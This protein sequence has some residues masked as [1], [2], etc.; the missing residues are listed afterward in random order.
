MV[1]AIVKVRKSV[2]RKAFIAAVVIFGLIGAVA[3]VPVLSTSLSPGNP[4]YLQSNTPPQFSS[5]D[6]TL[7]IEENTPWFSTI[8]SPITATDS[9]T[10]AYSLENS[11]KS[12]FTID[13]ATGQLKTGSPLNYESRSSY[14]VKVTASDPSGA[15]AS[16]DVTINVIN[17]DESG[18]VSLSWGQPQVGTELT[19]TLSDPDGTISGE[20][21]Q[22]SRSVNRDSGFSDINGAT[23]ASYTPGTGDKSNYL[24]ATVSY[25]DAQGQGKSAQGT[26][27]RRAR[28][29][30]SSNNAPAFPAADDIYGGYACSGSDPDRGVCLYVRRST[31]VGGEIYNPAR[32]EDPD[33]GR[34][35]LLAGGYRHCLFQN[36]LTDWPTLHKAA[37]QGL[38][39]HNLLGYDKGY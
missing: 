36:R 30:P 27:L 14:M 32:A 9:D 3:L 19:A 39:Q 15:S 38:R 6:I 13:R 1:G 10:L 8:G 31:P 18:K 33:G 23:A 28:V 26:S 25:T 34:G 2:V 16:V 21:W 11:G 4:A 17:L 12:H 7:E 35:P 20:T 5:G 29:V 37:G 22:W 24:R